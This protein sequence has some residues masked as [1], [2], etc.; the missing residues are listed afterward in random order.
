MDPIKKNLDTINVARKIARRTVGQNHG[1]ITRLM[2]PSDFGQLLKP[3]VFLDQFDHEGEPFYLPLH[4]HS[5][6]ATLTYVAEG[7]VSY[8][9]PDGTRGTLAAG[10]VEWM[11]AGGGMWHGGGIDHA[12][13]TRG[14]QLWIALPPHLESGPHLG[15][16]Q[17]P[18][19]IQRHGPARVLL[20]SYGKAA[21][22]IQAP[23]S[24]NYLAVRLKAGESWSYQ[25]PKDHTVLWA[26]VLSGT[27]TVPDELHSGELAAFEPSNQSVLF[28]AVTDVEFVLGSA[29]AHDHDLFLGRYS[30]HTSAEALRAGETKIT[31]IRH[32]LIQE[33]RL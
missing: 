6:I 20:G 9:D 12:G 4:P 22:A 31:E 18:Q 27:V 1:A 19:E 2:S 29:A 21:S 32:R 15:L 28:I 7:G 26:S 23:S 30:V 25:P 11:Q 13:R 17:A 14:F 24:M 8:I 10:G 16:Y 5:G 33:G 3:F